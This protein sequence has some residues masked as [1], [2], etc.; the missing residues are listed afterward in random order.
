MKIEIATP[1]SHLFKDPQAANSITAASDCLECRE[2]AVDRNDFPRQELF[3]IDYNLNLPW[4]DEV[5]QFMRKAL[6]KRDLKLATIQMATC[7]D[8]PVIEQGMYRPAGRRFERAEMIRLARENVAWM[9]SIRPDLGIGIEN[10]NFYPTP[11]YDYVSDG[12]FISEVVR[13]NGLSF[14]LDIAHAQVTAHNRGIEYREYLKTLPLE[15]LIQ[16]HVCQPAINAQGM[17]YD[18]H[19]LPNQEMLAEVER[20][21]HT[22]PVRYITVEYYKNLPGLL[23][24]LQEVSRLVRNL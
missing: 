5:H 13:E 20:L 12:D 9:S 2:W 24:S 21:C 14:L 17:A 7:Y 23:R 16:L 15:R 3:H 1:I 10:N 19:G 18:A 8:A 22:H 6:N 11:A 4:N